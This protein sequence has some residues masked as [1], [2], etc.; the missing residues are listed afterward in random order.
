MGFHYL[1]ATKEMSQIVESWI[2]A[3]FILKETGHAPFPK[4]KTS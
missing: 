2:S 1:L 3:M 4:G